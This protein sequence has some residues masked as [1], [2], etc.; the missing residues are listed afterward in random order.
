MQEYVEKNLY[1]HF[2]GNP[3][4]SSL[5]ASP[6]YRVVLS[7]VAAEAAGRIEPAVDPVLKDIV[8]AMGKPPIRRIRVLIAGF[9]SLLIG[10][11]VGT[12]RDIV[13]HVAEPGG[14]RCG[15]PVSRD[16]IAFMIEGSYRLKN[17]FCVGTV[18]F[19]ADR[20]SGDLYRMPAGYLQFVCIWFRHATP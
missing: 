5:V 11:A 15:K 12:K 14:L 1:L 2:L 13:A 19:R 20:L 7:A 9:Q 17:N 16:P 18:A 3:C 4:L 8:P 10:M 6:A